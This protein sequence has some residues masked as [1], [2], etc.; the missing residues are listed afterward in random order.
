MCTRPRIV[1][2]TRPCSAAA[3]AHDTT[4]QMTARE[5]LLEQTRGS[6]DAGNG[7][8]REGV[9]RSG[10]RSSSE[11]YVLV[12]GSGARTGGDAGAA[13]A[14]EAAGRASSSITL[15]RSGWAEQYSGRH[16]R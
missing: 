14:E 15:I 3:R 13:E 10:P 6:A 9:G 7:A 8:T 4:A 1:L 11:A 2:S 5:M 12:S 16:I